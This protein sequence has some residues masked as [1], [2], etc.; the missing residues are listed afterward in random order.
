MFAWYQTYA[1][2]IQKR[3]LRDIRDVIYEIDRSINYIRHK[4]YESHGQEVSVSYRWFE[5][6]WD[7]NGQMIV[8][9]KN[10]IPSTNDGIHNS[11]RK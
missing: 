9:H 6:V 5:D 3:T 2:K 1:R 4:K 11:S 8:S 10:S 7:H